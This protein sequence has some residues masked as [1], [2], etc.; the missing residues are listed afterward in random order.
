MKITVQTVSPLDRRPCIHRSWPSR[1]C[2]DLFSVILNSRRGR[3]RRQGGPFQLR[4]VP[5]RSLPLQKI[6]QKIQHHSA[7][8]SAVFKN[9]SSFYLQLKHLSWTLKLVSA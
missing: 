9:R 8:L 4:A 2:Q 1:T 6:L 5:A 7:W 3:G